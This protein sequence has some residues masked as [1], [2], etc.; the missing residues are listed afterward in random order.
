MNTNDRIAKYIPK[1][2]QESFIKLPLSEI[3][4]AKQLVLDELKIVDISKERIEAGQL[5]LQLL[6]HLEFDREAA[7]EVVVT[8][9]DEHLEEHR[10]LWQ[11]KLREAGLRK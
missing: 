7:G 10:A 6:N 9:I 8:P 11:R 4:K 5:L 3:K 2:L 1:D